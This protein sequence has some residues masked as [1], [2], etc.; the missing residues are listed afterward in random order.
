VELSLSSANYKCSAGQDIRGNSGAEF[1]RVAYHSFPRDRGNKH[2]IRRLVS[3]A[4]PNRFGFGESRQLPGI[5]KHAHPLNG[6]TVQVFAG[7]EC[8]QPL[9]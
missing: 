9:V 3:K 7:N 1:G 2:G 6:K 5:K 8:P 4:V